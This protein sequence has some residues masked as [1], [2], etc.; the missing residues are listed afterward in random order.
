MAISNVEL[1]SLIDKGLEDNLSKKETKKLLKT[2]CN[3]FLKQGLDSFKVKL[4]LSAHVLFEIR[5][6]AILT[7][8]KKSRNTYIKEGLAKWRK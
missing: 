1:M 8:N 5:Y 3:K 7:E 4:L 6:D 2:L